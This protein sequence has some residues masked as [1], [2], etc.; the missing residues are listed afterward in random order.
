[1]GILRFERGRIFKERRVVEV[2]DHQVL[3]FIVVVEDGVV[4]VVHVWRC[5]RLRGWV[6]GR[7][8]SLFFSRNRVLEAVEMSQDQRKIKGAISRNFRPANER[9]IA[10]SFQL[11]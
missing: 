2:L 8:P 9:V 3:V 4:V 6:D 5:S 1:M 10:R 11:F 7:V